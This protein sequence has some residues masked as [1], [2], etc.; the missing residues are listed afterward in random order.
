MWFMGDIMTEKTEMTEEAAKMLND[1]STYF[2]GLIFLLVVACSMLLIHIAIDFYLH[3][4]R[5]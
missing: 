1:L 3:V 5:P 2:Y 4:I